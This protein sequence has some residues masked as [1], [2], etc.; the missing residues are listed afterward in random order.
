MFWLVLT[1]WTS[2]STFQ[3]LFLLLR[4]FFFQI[5]IFN[6]YQ[7]SD[8]RKRTLSLSF[9]LSPSHSLTHTHTTHF[10][11]KMRCKFVSFMIDTSLLL[12][13]LIPIQKPIKTLSLSLWG[14]GGIMCSISLGKN[15]K[16]LKSGWKQ[17][18]TTKFFPLSIK[19]CEFKLRK[20]S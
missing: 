11:S 16:E 20:T 4:Q 9:S 14:G 10:S 7:F 13:L 6:F 18:V 5:L 15:T 3:K 1:I 8:E 19:C 12:T 17:I 2:S